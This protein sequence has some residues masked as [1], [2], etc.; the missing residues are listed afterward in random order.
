KIETRKKCPKKIQEQKK[1]DSHTFPMGKILDTFLASRCSK[2]RAPREM[3]FVVI[4]SQ[5]VVVLPAK[6]ETRK[7]CPKKSRNK[8]NLALIFPTA[9]SRVYTVQF[10]AA[11]KYGLLCSS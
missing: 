4:Y 2:T 8:R 11:C 7:K 6:I 1:F 5:R 3:L 10:P 9:L